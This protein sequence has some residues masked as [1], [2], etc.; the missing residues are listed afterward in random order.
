VV[1]EQQ[2]VS[3]RGKALALTGAILQLG[4]LVGLAGTIIGIRRA[5]EQLGTSGTGIGDPAHLSG[6][7]GHVLI[8]ALVGFALS[9]VGLVLLFI[10]L[11]RYHYRAKWFL[12]FLAVSCGLLL[13]ALLLAS[14]IA[15]FG[16]FSET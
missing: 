12:G 5:F 4:P 3:K 11:L 14:A 2:F 8:W 9:V 1:P 13:L 7:I 6:A 10:A 16:A 15:V